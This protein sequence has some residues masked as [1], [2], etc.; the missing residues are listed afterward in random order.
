LAEDYET[1]YLDMWWPPGHIIGWEH[2]FIHE[3][4]DLLF[5]IDKKEELRP[6]F[7][8]GLRCQQVL[9]AVTSS[10]RNNR[11]EHIGDVQY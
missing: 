4:G 7:I 9:E 5:A 1:N 8:D 2:T 10:V 6:D 3:I 11:W